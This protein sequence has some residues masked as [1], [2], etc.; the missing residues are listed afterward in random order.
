MTGY[1]NAQ[2]IS[3]A[4]YLFLCGFLFV[5]SGC[6]NSLYQI[7]FGNSQDKLRHTRSAAYSVDLVVWRLVS[8]F[9]FRCRFR[10][11]ST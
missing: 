5:F 9:T 8:K 4:M 3:Q 6:K 1:T 11:K 7:F 2:M 10:C